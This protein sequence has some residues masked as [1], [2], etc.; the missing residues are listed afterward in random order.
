MSL[1]RVLA[2]FAITLHPCV[3]QTSSPGLVGLLTADEFRQA[4]LSKLT[5]SEV[6]SLN[7]A[8]M[9]VFLQ[10]G[11]DTQSGSRISEPRIGNTTDYFDSRG[12]AVDY[13]DDDETLYLWSGEPVAY[14][15]EDNVFGF[16]GK[17]LGWR[18][19]GVIYDHDG[20]VVAAIASRLKTPVAAPP[21]KA[22]KDF[23]PFKAFKEF[24]PFKPFFGTAWSE[25][26]AR[27]FFRQG[28]Q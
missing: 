11:K 26:P 2:I 21:I 7:V 4:G 17:H 18:K 9:R 14:M 27:S 13:F 1:A 10:I 16:N 19:D 5:P 24:K 12:A 23:K 20:C 28:I 8:M 25:N 15:D 3:G 6:Q 22:F